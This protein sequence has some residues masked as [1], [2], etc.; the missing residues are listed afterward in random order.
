M[1][2]RIVERPERDNVEVYMWWDGG[3]GRH[4][5]RV[6]ENGRIG[7]CFYDPAPAGEELRPTLIFDRPTWAALVE[8]IR[9]EGPAGSV[10]QAALKDARE[11]RDRL[12]GMVERE[13]DAKVRDG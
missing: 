6:E 3:R 7:S 11:V 13:W 9:Q 5:A 2:V 10:E 8:A 4:V 1:K 12:L